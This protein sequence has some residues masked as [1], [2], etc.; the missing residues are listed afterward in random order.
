MRGLRNGSRMKGRE[1]GGGG[2]GGG[3][4]NR[5]SRATEEVKPN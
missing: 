1:P 5:W 3:W 2:G 4:F